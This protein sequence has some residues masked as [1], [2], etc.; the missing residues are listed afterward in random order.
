[1]C[2][3]VRQPQPLPSRLFGQCL[4][5]LRDPCGYFIFGRGQ[6]TAAEVGGSG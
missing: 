3:N 4:G 5:L 6:R 1:M 2:L